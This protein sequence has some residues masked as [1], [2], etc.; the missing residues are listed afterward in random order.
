MILAACSGPAAQGG[1]PSPAPSVA[2]LQAAIVT[3]DVVVGAGRRIT[4]GIVDANQVPVADV[5]VR[6]QLYRLPP[7]GRTGPVSLGPARS[8]P[9]EGQLLQ[10]KGVYT[11]HQSFDQA[12]FYNAVVEAKK[13]DLATTTEAA[14]QVLEEDTNPAIGTPAPPTQ[15]P[16][17]DQVSDLTTI[18]TGV[19]P[20]DMHYTSIAA[21]IAAH[22]PVVIYFGSP[23][24]CVSKTCG[25]EVEVVK[26]LEA[27]YRVKGIDFVHIETYKG[28]RPDTNHTNSPWFDEW[29][30]Q[31][32][33]WVFVVDRAGLVAAKFEGPTAPDEID[34]SL[35]PLAGS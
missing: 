9:Y 11:I 27:K 8:A 18:D 35:A 30:L 16:T 12:G 7:G 10:G 21:A 29:K 34:P 31:S 13:G 15:N 2:P 26:T 20:D 14:F 19:P 25:P 23:G 4:F 32:D 22:H 6:V 24:F 5:A 3:Q 1:Q 17:R 33:P 28:G